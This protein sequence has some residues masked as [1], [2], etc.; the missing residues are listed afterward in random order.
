MTILKNGH[1]PQASLKSCSQAP[2][3]KISIMANA[4][5]SSILIVYAYTIPFYPSYCSRNLTDYVDLYLI[6][7]I[8]LIADHIKGK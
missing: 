6:G 2:P 8:S 1:L 4:G 5:Y 3:A 7:E